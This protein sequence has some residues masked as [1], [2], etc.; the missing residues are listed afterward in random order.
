MKQ[1]F[2]NRNKQGGISIVGLITALAL[3]GFVGIFASRLI[4]AFLEYS[5]AK[6]AIVQIKQEGGTIRAMQQSFDRLTIVND[7]EALRGTD[8]IFERVPDGSGFDIS[9][10]Y[11]KRLPLVANVS[12]LIDFEGS[13]APAAAKQ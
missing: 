12:I 1:A 7:V 6:K 9:F 10:A 4:P 8:L 11:E 5:A 13:T 2:G 3:I